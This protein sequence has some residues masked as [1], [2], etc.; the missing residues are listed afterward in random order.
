MSNQLLNAVAKNFFVRLFIKRREAK[1]HRTGTHASDVIKPATGK[2]AY[3]PRMMVLAG[4]YEPVQPDVSPGLQM[5][6]DHGW[7]IHQ[8][9]QRLFIETGVAVEVETTHT[10]KA[11]GLDFTP[12]AVVMY[13]GKPHVIEIKGW[14]QETFEKVSTVSPWKHAKYRSAHQQCNFYMSMLGIPDGM[15]LI[16]NKNNQD[17]KVFVIESDPTMVQPFLDRL[18]TIQEDLDDFALTSKLPTRICASESST[19]A[20]DCPYARVCW[21]EQSERE[22][23]RLR[24]EEE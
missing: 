16:E 2:Q 4:H 5:I 7:A 21:L 3:C 20:A 8:K 23:Y 15:V 13:K 18:N 22:Q 10:D 9:W 6:F 14:N 24:K 17:I 11:H 12:D 1:P 19:R